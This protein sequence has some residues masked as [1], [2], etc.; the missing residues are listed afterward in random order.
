VPFIAGPPKDVVF[1]WAHDFAEA[2]MEIYRL[3]EPH[4][5][6][7]DQA[8]AKMQADGTPQTLPEL[9]DLASSTV[10]R[11]KLGWYR[12]N[13]FLG[14]LLGFCVLMGMPKADARYLTK[15]IQAKVR[16]GWSG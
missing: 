8:V 14:G 1:G 9:V 15:L 5:P 6:D 10:L 11:H 3:P 4:A 2:A 7:R 16:Q 12:R 13:Q